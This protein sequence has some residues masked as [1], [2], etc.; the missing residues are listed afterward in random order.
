VVE[1]EDEAMDDKA[2]Q[3]S[4]CLW[5]KVLTDNYFN[6]N[7]M[8]NIFKNVLKLSKGVIIRDLDKNLFAFQFFSATDK[9]FVLNKGPWA[10]D[11]DILILK[12]LSGFGQPSKIQFTKAHLWVKA[13]DV[14][15]IK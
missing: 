9:G 4:L 7:A 15:L 8:K 12:E 2:E 1:C 5:G 11:G 10:F 6:A 14:P 3:M 13:M